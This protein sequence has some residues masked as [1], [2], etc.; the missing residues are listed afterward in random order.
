MES[1]GCTSPRVELPAAQERRVADVMVKRPKTLPADATV[2]QVRALFENPRVRTAL[3]VDG[4]ALAGAIDTGAVPASVPD[5]EPARDHLAA[6]LPH[7]GPDAPMSEALA[8][9]E[10]A[11]TRRIAVVDA[12]GRTLR[13]LL[14]LDR[15]GAGFCTD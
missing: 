7:I 12:D 14:C 5:G 15:T 10:A 13:G 8:A 9:L 6:N 4:D 3:L 2:G 11:G 1:S